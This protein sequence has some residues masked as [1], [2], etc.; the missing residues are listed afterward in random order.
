MWV[1]CE[2]VA[3]YH[4]P[5]TPAVNQ[6]NKVSC[7]EVCICQLIICDSQKYQELSLKGLRERICQLNCQITIIGNKCFFPLRFCLSVFPN[8]FLR[9]FFS[10]HI[11]CPL[12]RAV[13]S[14]WFFADYLKFVLLTDNHFTLKIPGKEPD[15]W[16][17]SFCL[18]KAPDQVFLFLLVVIG[19]L[20]SI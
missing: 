10:F 11:F 17:L 3:V 20:S 2:S 7:R 18:F 4:F 13:I 1:H 5:L 16:N 8:V 14:L 15:I 6:T 19:S 12:V 9:W